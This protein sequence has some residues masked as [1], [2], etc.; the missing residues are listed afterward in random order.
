MGFASVRL[1]PTNKSE[2]MRLL[3]AASGIS[4]VVSSIRGPNMWKIQLNESRGWLSFVGTN[5]QADFSAPAT[6]A[7]IVVPFSELLPTQY[8]KVSSDGG[9]VQDAIATWRV[10]DSC[11]RS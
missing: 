5:W 8:G 6:A 2:F 1:T 10:L 11:Y 4:F 3:A 9:R 7:E